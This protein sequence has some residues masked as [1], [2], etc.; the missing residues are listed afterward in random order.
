MADDNKQLVASSEF[1]PSAFIKGID[2][3]TASLEKLSAQEDQLQQDMSNVNAAL[4]ENRTALKANQ[5]QIAALDRQSKTYADDLAKLNAQQKT[6]KDQQK[7]LQATLKGQKDA[8]TQVNKAANDYRGAIQNIATTARQVSQETKGRTIFDVGSLN[9]QVQDVITTTSRLRGI[10]QG[11]IDTKEL[12]KFEQAIAGTSDE[13]QQLA[14]VLEFVKSKMDTLDPNSQEFADL[15]KVIETG[16]QVLDQYNQTVERTEKGSGS[17]RS[18]LAALRNELAKLE[19]QGKENSQE[20]QDMAIEAGKLQDQIGDTQARIKILASDTKGIDF[21]IGA[22]RGV[23]SAFGVAEGA[24]ALFGIKNEDVAESIQRLNA[25]MLILNGL[26]EIQNLLQKQSVVFVVGQAIATKAAAIAQ[27]IYAAA[28]GTS[29]GAMK[30]FRLALLA[31]GIGAFVVLLGLAVEAMSSFGDETEATTVSVEQFDAA[32]ESVELRLK[33]FNDFQKRDATIAEERLKRQ[34]ANETKFFDLRI[35]NLNAER[36]ETKKAHDEIRALQ[37]DY[38]NRGG[39]D[40]QFIE[41]ANQEATRLFN[42]LREIDDQILIEQEKEQTRRFEAARKEAEKQAELYRSYLDRL[43]QLQREL[44]DKTLEAQAQDEGAIRQR[45]KNQLSDLTND[46]DKEVKEGKLTKVRGAALKELI[47]KINKVDLDKALK[48]FNEQVAAAQ[49]EQDRAIFDLRLQNAEQRAGLLAEIG[50]REAA[51]LKSG[52][53]RAK[54]ELERGLADQLKAIQDTADQGFI[55]PEQA[56]TNSDQVRAIYAQLLENLAAQTQQ[57]AG[58]LAGNIFARGQEEIS[59]TFRSIG[60]SVSQAATA[61]IIKLTQEFQSGAINY[62]KYQKELTRIATAES[63]KRIEQQIQ[64][65]VVLLQGVLIRQQREQDP[66]RQKELKDQEVQLRQQLAD[67][68][69]QLAGAEAQDTQ[70]ADAD[71]N[72]RIQRIATYAQA[73]G[74]IVNQ[75]VAFWQMA[76]EAEQRALERS[77]SLQERRV[78]AATRIAERGNAEYLRLEEDRL[79]ELQVKQEN[80]ARRQMAINAVLQTSQALTAFV[81]ALAQGI[82]TGGPLGGIAIATAVIGLIASGYAIISSLQQKNQ[83]TFFK[84]TKS[85]KRENGE[86]AGRDTVPAMVNEGEAIIPTDTNREYAPTVA[87]IYDRAIPAED[88]NAFVNSY[89]TNSRVIPRLD[90]DRISEAAGVVVTYDGQLLEATQEQNRLMAENNDRLA[91]VE[92]RLKTM[93]ITATVDKNGIAISLMKAVEQFKIDKN[94]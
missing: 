66:Q 61:E 53:D 77:I 32:L 39:S 41:D 40:A 45:L 6:L 1:D 48:D 72:A 13:M 81:T 36:E 20:F 51:Q 71:N 2:A 69:R 88:M 7:E 22:I 46:I 87:A 27:G 9:K 60:L 34:N 55:S 11:K 92:K 68:R 90:H 44:R 29:T 42:R 70:Q 52:Y 43:T 93:G 18:K 74:G 80:A 21:G 12:D 67:L 31:T 14:Q 63:K 57:K 4:K 86:P 23:A 24:A 94:S 16:E 47:K 62:D 3:M 26:Q 54:T 82:A 76:N 59:R 56:Q 75:V 28:V 30:A 19:D 49:I 38:L 17:L 78:D 65:N 5:D 73:I 64:E 33:A 50:E 8:L 25:I 85:V 79:N 15:N 58:E 10:F 83:P 37:D 91:L 35:N 84:G 89:R